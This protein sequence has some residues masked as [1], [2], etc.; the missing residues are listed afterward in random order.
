M[1]R[2]RGFDPEEQVTFTNIPVPAVGATNITFTTNLIQGVPIILK[3]VFARRPDVAPTAGGGW[4]PPTE[5]IVETIN[6]P[7]GF[8]V[9]FE[10]LTA[11]DGWW[12]SEWGN[13]Q[14]SGAALINLHSIP[15]NVTSLDISWV[16]QK[17]RTVE[18]LVKPPKAE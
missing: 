6:P 12:P 5:V 8:V 1:Q 14:P 9:A 4:I 13:S 17:T 7:D 15:T 10:R 18:F 2:T 11:A 3:Q 16:V